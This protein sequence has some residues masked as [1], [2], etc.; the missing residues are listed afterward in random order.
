ML[1]WQLQESISLQLLG[2]FPP[3]GLTQGQAVPVAATRLRTALGSHPGEL[4]TL[5]GRKLSPSRCGRITGIGF[6]WPGL[7]L[8]PIPE[9]VTV[10]T[11][12]EGPDWVGLGHVSTP[13]LGNG[14]TPLKPQT[15]PQEVKVK[16]SMPPEE[17]MDITDEPKG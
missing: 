11:E 7:D 14:S 1:N 9:P 2:S 5:V 13:N 12:M 15:K 10:A 3:D 6:C 17:R 8:V 4:S 16:E